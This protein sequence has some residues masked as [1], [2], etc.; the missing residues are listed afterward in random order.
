MNERDDD[1]KR[2]FGELRDADRRAMQPPAIG[3][4]LARPPRRAGGLVRRRIALG[5]AASVAVL[6]AAI[7]V[8]GAMHRAAPVTVVAI[9]SWTSPTASL[10]A[11]PGAQVVLPSLT[12]SAVHLETT[13]KTVA[14]DHSRGDSI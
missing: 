13:V 10:L 2:V 4:L 11:V 12:S 1:L 6:A 5:L 9:A 14:K 3:A 8:R 7:G